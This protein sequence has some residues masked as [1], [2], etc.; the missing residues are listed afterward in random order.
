MKDKKLIFVSCLGLVLI[1]SLC[2]LLFL[3]TGAFNRTVD[4]PV[5]YPQGPDNVVELNPEDE[6]DFDFAVITTGETIELRNQLNEVTIINLEK[7]TWKDIQW[8]PNNENIAVLG[9]TAEGIFDIFVYNLES[10][11]WTMLTNYAEAESGVTSFGWVTPNN[12]YFKQ[13]VEGS[14][15]LHKL[16]IEAQSNSIVKIVQIEGEIIRVS[17][18]GNVIALQNVNSFSLLNILGEEINTLSEINFINI[19]EVSTSETITTVHFPDSSNQ[20]IYFTSNFNS[21]VAN[22]EEASGVL[23]SE[24]EAN[25]ICVRGN[26]LTG[27]DIDG[28]NLVAL[29]GDITNKITG[30]YELNLGRTFDV[31]A[32]RSICYNSDNF[33]INVLIAGNQRWYMLDDGDLSQSQMVSAIVEITAKH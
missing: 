6:S 26:T 20:I 3:L 30:E 21:V 14:S 2:L 31:N 17:D 24:F 16:N 1:A 7:K 22:V 11:Q 19:A 10:K 9:E 5:S 29:Q 4:T 32:D 27:Y 33:L 18:D 12:I 28:T 25:P 13:V 23:L 8:S 15:W